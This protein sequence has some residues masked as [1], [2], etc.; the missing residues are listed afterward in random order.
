MKT[1]LIAIKRMLGLTLSLFILA[2]FSLFAQ[3]KMKITTSSDEAK[4]L[5]DQGIENH[6][7]FKYP[8]ALKY[9]NKA[10][11]ID[12]KFAMAHLYL[13]LL[14]SGDPELEKKHL[15]KAVELK[16][17]VSEGEKNMILYVKASEEGDEMAMKQHIKSLE[18]KYPEDERVISMTGWHHYTTEN[19][20]DALSC[21]KDAVDI[22][23][24]Y[25]PA[26]NMLG[27]T[28]WKLGNIEEAESSFLTYIELVPDIANS[29]DS[30]ASFLKNQ[31]KFGKATE[32]YKMALNY[33]PKYPASLKGLGD[34]YLF[35]GSYG[36]A[37]EYYK[38][39]AESTDNNNNK[40]YGLLLEASVELHNNNAEEALAIMDE[41]IQMAENK[42]LPFQKI[43]AIAYKGYILTETGK[44]EE[45]LE[46]YMKA[47]DIIESA[48]MSEKL[49]ERMR[50]NAQLWR[51]YAL[52]SNDNMV[53]AG[54]EQEK[55][56]QMLSEKG[57]AYQWKRFN[58]ISGLLEIKKGNYEK[59]RN[60]LAEGTNNPTN[61]YYTGLAW[62]LSGN[63]TK[64]HE[65]YQKVINYYENSIELGTS[66]NKAMAWIKE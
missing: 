10:V 15:Q 59:A 39:Y 21:F 63:T 36:L 41:Y 32:E 16:N 3:E 24:L 20:S 40:F 11:E 22:N 60:Y 18:L 61:W 17:Q 14:Q 26:Y 34:I 28:Y 57:S 30:Y 66:R 33:E 44:P 31:G 35:K 25:H 1:Q 9:F 2:S 4:M 38:K 54:Q 7:M 46:Y 29:H 51:F 45:G 49:R 64:A 6:E 48:E 56:K 12:P 5:Y 47:S 50:T 37:R 13:S 8:K 23:N 58:S 52:T 27:Y 42:Q 43:N 65:Y 19:Y 53:K 55:C 62:D